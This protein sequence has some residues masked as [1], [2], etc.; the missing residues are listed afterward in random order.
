[1]FD[2]IVSLTSWA[3]RINN[4]A[5]G[6]TLFSIIRQKTK[7]KY[8]IVLVLSE[9][10]FPTHELP[11]QLQLII[12]YGNVEV[13]WTPDNLKAYK[14]YYYTHKKYPDSIIITTDD[15]MLVDEDA[16]EKM[17]DF[18][19]KHKGCICAQHVHQ[20]AGTSIAGYFR[21]YPPNSM[22]DVDKIYFE[23]CYNCIADDEYNA[24]LAKCKGTKTVQT[25]FIV[26]REFT[27]SIQ[28]S[29]LR[30]VYMK[31]NGRINNNKLMKALK[32]AGEIK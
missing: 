22:L 17:M 32:L 25:P 8:K 2:C 15:D 13:I 14:K 31:I 12:D 10:E 18:Y 9:L 19:Q 27:G 5:V 6:K 7:Y 3:G 16:V 21:L 29:A 20:F 30:K 1:M 28:Q 26:A 23:K 11:E 4:P 24:V